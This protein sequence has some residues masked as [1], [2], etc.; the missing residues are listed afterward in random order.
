[1][2]MLTNVHSALFNMQTDLHNMLVEYQNTEDFNKMTADQFNDVMG[3]A[4]GKVGNMTQY[5]KG[6]S[7][8]SGSGSDGDKDS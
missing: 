2:D 6:D 5:G 4:W 1:M 8:G 3:D 7:T